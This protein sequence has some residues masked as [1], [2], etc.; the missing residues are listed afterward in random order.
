M[1]FTWEDVANVKLKPTDQFTSLVQSVKKNPGSS[2][3]EKMT[4]I[5][6]HDGVMFFLCDA[7][8]L[9]KNKKLCA[10]V[11]VCFDWNIG[12][13]SMVGNPEVELAAIGQFGSK[14]IAL[15][16]NKQFF[17]LDDFTWKETSIPLLPSDN[18]QDP[19]ILTYQS[20]LLVING[21]TV[22]I[23]VTGYSLNYPLLMVNWTV[24]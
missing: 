15:K 2:I 3:L 11:M 9:K 22:W 24:P 13:F 4:P 5:V 20:L 12:D 14:V 7:V 1:E 8:Y 21:S 23:F 6:N 10:G 19:V 16:T 17:L 18:L